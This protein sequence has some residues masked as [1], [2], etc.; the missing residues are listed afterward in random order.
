MFPRAEEYV[1]KSGFENPPTSW[2]DAEDTGITVMQTFGRNGSGVSDKF[3]IQRGAQDTD[4]IPRTDIINLW[5]ETIEHSLHY[6]HMQPAINNVQQVVGT[7]E[8]GKTVGKAGQTWWKEHLMLTAQKGQKVGAR[9]VKVVDAIRY[10]V[11]KAMLS[12]K[13]STVLSQFTAPINAAFIALPVVGIEGAGRV[14]F[15]SFK[16][17]TPGIS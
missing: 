6:I 9:K 8:F 16:A 10:N 14:L 1:A 15:E 7:R 13:A 3:S 2:G 11:T 5:F 12:F 4:L 17:F